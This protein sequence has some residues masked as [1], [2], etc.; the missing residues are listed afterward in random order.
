MNIFGKEVWMELTKDFK[1]RVVEK[2]LDNG[3]SYFV[4]EMDLL[5]GPVADGVRVSDFFEAAKRV[6]AKFPTESLMPAFTDIW[7]AI[8]FGRF[9]T[10]L[11]GKEGMG[12]G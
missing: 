10:K 12:E 9:L 2:K 4:I 7:S 11:F 6:G 5:E 3:P 8:L 1:V